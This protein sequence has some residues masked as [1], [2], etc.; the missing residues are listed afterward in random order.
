M[1]NPCLYILGISSEWR[2]I[3]EGLGKNM[4]SKMKLEVLN[5][6]IDDVDQDL[7]DE[8]IMHLLLDKRVSKPTGIHE[9]EQETFGERT[10]DTIARSVGSWGFIIV[11]LVV[12]FSWICVNTILL[13][14]A[15]DPY[16]F[17]LLN[18]VLSCIAAIQA[19]LILMSQNRQEKKDRLR[20][21][22]DYKVNLKSEIIMQ[23]LHRKMDQIIQNQESLLPVS[24]DK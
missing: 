9:K 8:E 16:P 24:D 5:F 10:S 1:T 19:P 20:A 18:L 15:Y 17:I 21:E 12:L 7:M 14:R 23:D 13:S 22:N 3:L 4:D 6:I 11:F 2:K